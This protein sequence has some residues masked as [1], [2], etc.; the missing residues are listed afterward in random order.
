MTRRNKSPKQMSTLLSSASGTLAQINQKTKALKKIASIVRQICPDLPVESWHIANFS[1]RKVIIEVGS[2]VWG[3]RLQFERNQIAQELAKQTNG[4]FDTVEL[5]VNPYFNRKKVVKEE[6]EQPKKS[7]SSQSS[8]QLIAVAESAPP[9]L[10]EKLL[11]L[12]KH[13]N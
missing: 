12:A 3:Q 2:S 11:K 8:E 1:D 9:A 5:K 4:I 13:H 10:R 6:K 7:M